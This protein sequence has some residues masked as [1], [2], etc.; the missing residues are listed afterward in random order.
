MNVDK[1]KPSEQLCKIM[2]RIYD[3][4][5]TTVSG[6]NLSLKDQKGNIW[7]TPSGGDKGKYQSRDILK[8][9]PN[10]EIQG[11][12]KPS[13][14]TGIHR[15][16]LADRPEFKAV[17]HAHPPGLVAISLLREL[18]ETMILP[19]VANSIKNIK[20]AKYGCPGSEE[21]RE[22]VAKEFKYNNETN[23]AVLENH[24]VFIASE[25]GISHAF[26]IF[27]DL[28]FSVKIQAK[29]QKFSAKKPNIITNEQLKYYNNVGKPKYITFKSKKM[30]EKEI[31]LR[32]TICEF[33]DRAYKRNL[34][35][36]NIGVISARLDKDSF[37]ITQSGSD[38]A[39]LTLQEI[40]KVYGDAV[41]EGK[42][43]SKSVM[44]HKKIYE[45][46]PDINSIIMSAP[47]NAMVFAVT[48]LEYDLKTIPEC[49]IVL[50]EDIVK[51]PF[52]S[53]ISRQDE[54]AQY[55]KTKSPVAIIEN[56]CY[57]CTGTSIFNAFDKLEVVEFS[58]EAVLNANL[59]GGQ[60][61]KINYQQ[62]Q[63]IK[64]RFNIN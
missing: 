13:V 11:T 6:G 26:S 7:V 62:V 14:E 1:L 40:V 59:L 17:V 37:L 56:D 57:I 19:Q 33:C 31:E 16:I 12:K 32:K 41:E 44:L 9:L 53:T 2:S 36:Q 38:N 46:N 42:I 52:G 58:A 34:F 64:E 61:K 63:E 43:P 20:L 48:D 24:G 28:D 55:F 35:T 4:K 15:S 50:R 51:F 47:Q 25:I 22:N 39:E 30:L 5:L 45:E 27:K 54:L 60:L 23:T 8:I 49:Y 3:S 18:P 29:A 10:G 21:L